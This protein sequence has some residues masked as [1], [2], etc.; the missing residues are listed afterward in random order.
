LL[1]RVLG[2]DEVGERGEDGEFSS[3][4]LELLGV[5]EEHVEGGGVAEVNGLDERF[6]LL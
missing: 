5:L 4:V 1:N 6:E 2:I 3:G